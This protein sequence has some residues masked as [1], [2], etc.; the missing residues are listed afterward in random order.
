MSDQNRTVLYIV[1]AIASIGLAIWSLSGL[2]TRNQEHV[3]RAV[4]SEVARKEREANELARKKRELDEFNART[5][6]VARPIRLF[7]EFLAAIARDNKAEINKL[8]DFG[9]D[10]YDLLMTP[11]RVKLYGEAY[12]MKKYA[13]LDKETKLEPEKAFMAATIKNQRN[14]DVEEIGIYMEH[15]PG[16]AENWKVVEIETRYFAASGHTPESAR[17]ILGADRTKVAKPLTSESSF[18][19]APE[20]DPAP[21]EWLATTTPDQKK[22]ITEQIKILLNDEHPAQASKAS[23]VLVNFGKDAIPALLSEFV[24]YDVRKDDDNRKANA[25]DRTLAVMTDREMGY[26]AIGLESSKPEPGALTPAQARVRAVRRW[27]GW[28]GTHK[29]KPLVKRT[30]SSDAE[31]PKK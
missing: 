1:G 23:Q 25:I 16:G 18:Q 15:R 10:K 24:K 28:W 17:V 30:Q 14:M 26:D 9:L 7:H 20:A 21:Q 4:A 31:E 5:P 11:E 29:D 22:Q 19:V 8:S 2:F 12:G 6:V 13:V 3:D 27:F